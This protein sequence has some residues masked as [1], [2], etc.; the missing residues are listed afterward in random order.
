M[1]D[2]LCS[3]LSVLEVLGLIAA[4][5]LNLAAC[6][7]MACMNFVFSFDAP[8]SEEK[9]LSTLGLILLLVLA[10]LSIQ[11]AAIWYG[12]HLGK[13]W[14][15]LVL[16]VLTIPAYPVL[17]LVA[18]VLLSPAALSV[19]AAA[20]IAIDLVGMVWWTAAWVTSSVSA[21]LNPRWRRIEAK[22]WPSRVLER[23]A[24]A[25]KPWNSSRG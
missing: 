16:G 14:L 24:R 8:K 12:I 1:T 20:R 4:V 10:S 22:W 21:S 3:L 9:L 7:G 5:F 17:L 19:M 15:A 25:W 6:F 11:A 2:L 13:L 18:A 23:K